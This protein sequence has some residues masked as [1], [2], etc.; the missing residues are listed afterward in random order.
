MWLKIRS[1]D[2]VHP[3]CGERRSGRVIEPH[4]NA[5]DLSSLREQRGAETVQPQLNQVPKVISEE[6]KES[7]SQFGPNPGDYWIMTM[8]LTMGT[9]ISSG[10]QWEL[11]PC[12]RHTCS[13]HDGYSDQQWLSGLAGFLQRQ[14]LRSHDGYSDQQWLS[15]PRWLCVRLNKRDSRWVLR[16][17]VVVRAPA[18]AKLLSIVHSRWVLRSAVVVR[19]SP[20]VFS[21]A[22]PGSRW[23][24]R[25]AVVVS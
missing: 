15:V 13:A 25:S 12:R 2:K 7:R 16:S 8:C 23:V 10:C 22:R 3:A 21:S 4:R 11:E 1:K 9:Q 19:S 14:L 18:P 24:L 6:S 17:A 20:L 5:T